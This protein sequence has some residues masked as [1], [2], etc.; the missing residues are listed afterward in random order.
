MSSKLFYKCSFIKADVACRKVRANEIDLQEGKKSENRKR[1]RK[2]SQVFN[3]E[4]RIL[5]NYFHANNK[6]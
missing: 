1:K 3:I 2:I 4:S 6:L 5:Y